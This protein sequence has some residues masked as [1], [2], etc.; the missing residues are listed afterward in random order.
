M[1]I[2]RRDAPY[3]A[4]RNIVLNTQIA[5]PKPLLQLAEIRHFNFFV[6]TTFDLLLEKAIDTVRFGGRSETVTIAY[7]PNNVKDLECARE[8]L[9]R[10]TVYHLLGKLSSAPAYVI[11]DED[12]L[13]F[14]FALQSEPRRPQRLFDELEENHL[15]MLGENFSDWLARFFLRA[16][17]DHRL[18]D[19]REVVEILADSWTR[20]DNNLTL[21]LQNFSSRTLIFPGGGAIEFVD[22][23]GNGGRSVISIKSTNP[24]RKCRGAP[25]LSAMH[26]KT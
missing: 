7:S 1:G 17:K 15:L 2:M 16:A 10:P 4:I 8:S 22:N 3:A 6:T 12:L 18:S 19:W 20:C 11:C 9:D 26:G 23:F 21:F 5:P 25:S 14:L 13:E 24:C